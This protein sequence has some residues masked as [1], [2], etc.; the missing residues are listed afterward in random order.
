MAYRVKLSECHAPRHP[1]SKDKGDYKERAY[2]NYRPASSIA[3]NGNAWIKNQESG[4]Y[5]CK[6]KGDWHPM[7]VEG[8]DPL[9]ILKILAY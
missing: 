3:S 1:K 6:V 2:R 7:T 8:D 4:F 9:E 5:T